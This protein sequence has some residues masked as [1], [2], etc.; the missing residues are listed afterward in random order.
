[1]IETLLTVP[2]VAAH[3]KITPDTVHSWLR[4]GKLGGHRPGG[5]RMGWRVSEQELR[6][7]PD[8]THRA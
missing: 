6:R 2:E 1:M 7:L 8:K 4:E 3:F 5:T